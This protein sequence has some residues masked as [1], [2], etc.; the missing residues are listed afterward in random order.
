V[1]TRHFAAIID[2]EGA[3]VEPGGLGL[4]A[5]A[6]D[7]ARRATACRYSTRLSA[8]AAVGGGR[9]TEAQVRDMLGL[10]DRARIFEIVT[11]ALSGNV[12]SALAQLAAQNEQGAD[13]T[14][15]VEDLLEM[16][17]WLTR[18]KMKPDGGDERTVGDP[19]VEQST[20]GRRDGGG[21]N[22]AARSQ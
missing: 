22:G 13:P 1:L 15:V 2:K 8:M 4:I 20:P 21:A 10:A 5:R 17:H 12:T 14:V 3:S 6:A 16:T 7:A 18:L 9:V 11:A 19:R